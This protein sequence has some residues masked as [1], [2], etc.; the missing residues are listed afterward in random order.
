MKT[1]LLT[2]ILA[3][4]AFSADC[5]RLYNKMM[6]TLPAKQVTTICRVTCINEDR[7]DI[8]GFFFYFDL[9]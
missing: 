4:S 2:L 9:N 7:E 3:I 8:M 5:G 6:K 1:L